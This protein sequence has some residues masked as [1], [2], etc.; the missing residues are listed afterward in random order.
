M[1]SGQGL[2]RQ[3]ELKIKRIIAREFLVLITVLAI[4]IISYLST[5]PY[6]S[7]KRQQEG[8]LANK[9]NQIEKG[10]DSLRIT[11]IEIERNILLDDAQIK[12]L[13]EFDQKEGRHLTLPELT[14][15]LNSFESRKSYFDEFNNSMKFKSY[16]EFIE[17]IQTENSKTE[18]KN[19]KIQYNS[20]FAKEL[21]VREQQLKTLKDSSIET[22]KSIL[23]KSE[24]FKL[25]FS[26]IMTSFALLFLVRYFVYATLWSLATLRA[27]N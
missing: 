13:W 2:Q 27:K 3:M 25:S 4:G 20:M 19:R 15:L 18:F 17:L 24:Q 11:E 5:Y 22:R 26:A 23:T 7:S 16:D 12:L 1:P 10:I 14:E 8:I 6:N 21:K 9:I